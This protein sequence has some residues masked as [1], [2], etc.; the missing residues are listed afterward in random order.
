M[1]TEFEWKERFW[2]KVHKTDRCWLWI[3][4]KFGSGYGAFNDRNR[5]PQGAHRISWLFHFG[6]IPSGLLVCHHCD[7]PICVRP[8]HLFV[9]TEKDNQVDRVRKGRGGIGER[10]G[11]SKLTTEKVKLMRQKLAAGATTTMV[12]KEFGVSQEMASYIRLNRYWKEAY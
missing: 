1:L 12:A 8:D 6:E 10:N 5:K 4:G 2:Q 9:G 11:N 3:G 7:N